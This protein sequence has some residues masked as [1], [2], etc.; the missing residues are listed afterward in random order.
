MKEY[1]IVDGYNIIGAWPELQELKETN[2]EH[3]RARL[4]EI[5]RTR[6]VDE[7]TGH[8]GF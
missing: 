1:L 4:I 8:S 6:S 3:A 5:I 2:L 7:T